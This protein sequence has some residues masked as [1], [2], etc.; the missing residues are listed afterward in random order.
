M[1]WPAALPSYSAT[2]HEYEHS[3]IHG[4]LRRTWHATVSASAPYAFSMTFPTRCT[5]PMSAASSSVS[6]SFNLGTGRVGHTSTS[7]STE[8]QRERECTSASCAH[9]EAESVRTTGYDWF[10]VHDGKRQG[11][12]VKDLTGD[13]CG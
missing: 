7:S 12:S 4:K 3:I 2:R 10:Q 6:K 13:V 5:E 11:C 8:A 9:V 1:D